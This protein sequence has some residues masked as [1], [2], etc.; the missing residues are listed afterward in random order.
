MRFCGEVPKLEKGR[1]GAN[2]P[3][4]GASSEQTRKVQNG[5]RERERERKSE[6]ERDCIQ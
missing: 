4:K 2:V 5:E 1:S 6:S 3:H